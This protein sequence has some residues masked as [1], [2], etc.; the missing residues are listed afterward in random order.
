MATEAKTDYIISLQLSVAI[1]IIDYVQVVIIN[2]FLSSKPRWMP[3]WIFHHLIREFT[4]HILTMTPI[5]SSVINSKR[6]S[7]CCYQQENHNLNYNEQYLWDMTLINVK[8]CF[9]LLSLLKTASINILMFQLMETSEWMG[10][11]GGWHWESWLEKWTSEL[12]FYQSWDFEYPSTPCKWHNMLS[13]DLR[14]TE[15]S[16]GCLVHWKA[17]WRTRTRNN[18]TVL[19]W[20]PLQKPWNAKYSSP[21]M[22]SITIYKWCYY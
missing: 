12:H 6:W 8:C 21:P 17:L 5:L 16:S 20:F 14:L 9:V 19:I 10:E 1:Q 4:S 18:Q 22:S 13:A 11:I 3:C 15:N 2:G 7:M